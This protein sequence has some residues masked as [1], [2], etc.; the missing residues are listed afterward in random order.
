MTFSDEQVRFALTVMHEQ[1]RPLPVEGTI[2]RWCEGDRCRR[3]QLR[4]GAYLLQGGERV[5]QRP[6]PPVRCTG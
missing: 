1:R 5:R 6:S 3:Y 2:E 4:F